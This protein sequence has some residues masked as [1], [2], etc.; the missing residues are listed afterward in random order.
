MKDSRLTAVLMTTALTLTAGCSPLKPTEF[1][2]LV[3]ERSEEILKAAK[4]SPLMII[5]TVDEERKVFVNQESA[6]TTDDVSPL[7]E[8]LAQALERRKEIL[9]AQADSRY[10][11]ENGESKQ[12]VVFVRAPSTFTYGDVIKVVEAIKS[13]GGE[14]IGLHQAPPAGK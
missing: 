13:V 9:R 3:P 8:K 11:E 1:K 10:P 12:K 2:Q 7:K 5:V 4:E 6:G 14:P